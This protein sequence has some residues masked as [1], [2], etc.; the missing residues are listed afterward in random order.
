MSN[1]ERPKPSATG[2]VVLIAGLVTCALGFVLG[3][4]GF[5]VAGATI[6]IGAVLA[7]ATTLSVPALHIERV[8]DTVRVERG[9]PAHGLVSV[10]NPKSRRS[11]A[12]LAQET[13]GS[14]V[15]TV[16]IPSLRKGR[17]VVV[18]Y[19]LP[20]NRRGQMVVG[21]LSVRQQDPFG[22]FAASR[23]V[24]GTETV[25]VEPKIFP[26]DARPSGRL[27]HLDGPT[28]DRSKGTMTFHSLREYTRGDDIR[29]VHWR[30]SARTGTLMV[31]EHVDTSLPSTVVVLDTCADHYVG[32][33]FEEAVDVAASV[34]AASLARNF[35]VRFVTAGGVNLNVRTGQ[36]G[37]ELRNLLSSI[38]PDQSSSLIGA[39][40]HV[41][42][43]NDHDALVVIG[44]E[45][46]SADFTMVS[47]MARRFSTPILVTIRNAG[48][49]RWSGVH[50]DGDTAADVLLQWRMGASTRVP[51]EASS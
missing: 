31:K 20:T 36:R 43:S 35:R 22:L 12:C 39:N 8:I 7:A 37:Q 11:R 24:G 32:D 29:Q 45:L 10:T 17:S 2:V 47:A 18:P 26:I 19:E 28:S 48:T 46:A 25:W 6:I 44:G 49:A 50:F 3:Y 27:R 38:A 16:N 33:G 40:A 41:I 15:V 34:V 51:A 23:V 13:V 4:R 5:A 30:S 14:R 42:R 21:P 9:N 1:F